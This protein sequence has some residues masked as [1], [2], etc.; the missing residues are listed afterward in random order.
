MNIIEPILFQCKIGGEKPA[1]CLPGV[2]NT[3]VSYSQLGMM[4]ENITASLREYD[5]RAGQVVGV[6][7][8]DKIFHL[9]LT[10]A[11]IR[12]GVAT[13]SCR[14]R[15]LPKE[16]NAKA[17]FVDK[18]GPVENAKEV[19]IIDKQLLVTN[20]MPDKAA[21]QSIPAF[22][23]SSICRLIL[24]S[25][26][27]GIPKAVAF[28]HAQLI[29]RI[30]RFHFSF[31]DRFAQ[32]LRLFCDLGLTTSL[33]FLLPVFSLMRGGLVY[34]YGD[35]GLGSLQS[36]N[37]YKIQNM[38]TSPYNLANYVEFLEQR[39]NFAV[40]LDHIIVAGS[41]VHE[42]LIDRV[43]SRLCPRIVN[44]YGASEIG[45]IASAD[46]REL[47]GTPGAVGFVQPG[48]KVEIVDE[49]GILLGQNIDG[50]IRIKTDEMA[51][52]YYGDPTAS[53]SRFRDGWFYPG[54][55]GRLGSD[56][57][58]VLSGR[59]DLLINIGGDKMKPEPIEERLS[60]Y[61]GIID[62]AVASAADSP[63]HNKLHA[64]VV[65]RGKID[66]N[67]LTEFWESRLQKA[68]VPTSI[69][70]VETIPRND[71]GKIDRA[72]LLQFLR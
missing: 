7:I 31:C 13:V 56:G 24:T 9:V 11:L 26:T 14:G 40:D 1:L 71:M 21:S 12:L 29:K 10:L 32:C 4:I 6:F 30:G 28:S 55:I 65:S 43:W 66:Q 46:L 59:D 60:G 23:E 50:K 44:Q 19:Y 61:P 27:T 41:P 18:A 8:E 22:D 3:V 57:L 52:G 45:T 63:G 58:I 17:L 48:A 68:F 15:G 37:L 38:I 54:D 33:G 39:T 64:F 35:D 5:L 34:F 16:I 51:T 36:L 72:R 2:E 70:F 47:R 67:R 20:S 49:S 53:A 69:V 62:V 25:G 42:N